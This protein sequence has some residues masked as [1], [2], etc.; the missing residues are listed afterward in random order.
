MLL[1]ACSGTPAVGDNSNVNGSPSTP[2]IVDGY[3]NSNGLFIV[4]TI[5]VVEDGSNSDNGSNSNDNEN[6]GGTAM[7]MKIQIK[8]RIRIT[9]Q[10][11]APAAEMTVATII[12]A[13]L[14]AAGVTI[15]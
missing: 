4:T 5:V 14:V 12:T 7:I 8:M 10:V 11:P 15:M 9:T 2:V 13:V 6:T 3:F 1:S